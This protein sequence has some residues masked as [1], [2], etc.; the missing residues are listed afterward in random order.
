MKMC[1]ISTSAETDNK[2]EFGCSQH[3]KLHTRPPEG[4]FLDIAIEIISEIQKKF[5]SFSVLSR[6]FDLSLN[7]SQQIFPF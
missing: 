4:L 5:R 6:K 2:Q 1:H 7:D 3:Y